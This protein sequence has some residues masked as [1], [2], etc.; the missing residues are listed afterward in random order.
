MRFPDSKTGLGTLE[1]NVLLLLEKYEINSR[2]H[3]MGYALNYQG[4]YGYGDLQFE[5]VI[6]NLEPFIEDTGN[7]IIL[8]SLGKKVLKGKTNA[9]SIIN[10]SVKYGG[11]K[12][13]DYCFDKEQNKLI[14][15]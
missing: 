11:V 12:R 14:K 13:S 5:R 6:G 2:H 9:L 3:L 15:N 8:N 7:E 10:N 4:Y 1:H